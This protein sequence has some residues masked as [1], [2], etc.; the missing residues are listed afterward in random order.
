[1]FTPKVYLEKNIYIIC[2]SFVYL[3][4]EINGDSYT[5]G[6]IFKRKTNTHLFYTF[7]YLPPLVPKIKCT[8]FFET[9]NVFVR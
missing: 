3:F 8:E 6:W 2:L 7:I 4:I 1:M 9:L 5:K